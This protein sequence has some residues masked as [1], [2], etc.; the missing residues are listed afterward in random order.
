[1]LWSAVYITA[2]HIFEWLVG[3]ITL[4]KN[5]HQTSD[6]QYI[7]ACPKVLITHG[8]LPDKTMPR[9]GKSFRGRV[10]NIKLS[11]KIHKV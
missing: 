11:F 8:K 4:N 2:S 9:P 5:G 6:T 10:P 1:M 3:R 7:L